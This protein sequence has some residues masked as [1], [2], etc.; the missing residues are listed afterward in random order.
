MF[1]TWQPATLLGS[2]DRRRVAPSVTSRPNRKW[3]PASSSPSLAVERVK[4]KFI[5]RRP[6]NRTIDPTDGNKL[7]ERTQ[8]VP[9]SSL[10]LCS[11]TPTRQAARERRSDTHKMEV[12]IDSPNVRYTEAS[13]EARYEYHTVDVTRGPGG[14]VLVSRAV[15]RFWTFWRRPSD[16]R[17]CRVVRQLS[18]TAGWGSGIA[19]GCR[20]GKGGRFEISAG[21]W[22]LRDVRNFPERENR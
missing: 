15:L 19:A 14:K 10:L 9:R 7:P 5:Y 17:C 12:I 22:G 3:Q 21:F 18:E 8:R 20:P 1:G 13:I 4:S 6:W 16:L 11:S 2:L